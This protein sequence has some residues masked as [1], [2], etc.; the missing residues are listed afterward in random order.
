MSAAAAEANALGKKN[1]VAMI[2]A[3]MAV[4]QMPLRTVAMNR[5]IRKFGMR[6]LAVKKLKSVVATCADAK[7]RAG[8]G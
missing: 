2:I 1:V 5:L 7:A 3:A 6:T 8:N 4:A